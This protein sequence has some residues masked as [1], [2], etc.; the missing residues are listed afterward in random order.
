MRWACDRAYDPWNGQRTLASAGSSPG[1]AAAPGGSPSPKGRQIHTAGSFHPA[2]PPPPGQSPRRFDQPSTMLPPIG[3]QS[4]GE[5]GRGSGTWVS[6]AEEL[7]CSGAWGRGR[8]GIGEKRCQGSASRRHQ[9][10]AVSHR[11]GGTRLDTDKAAGSPLTEVGGGQP[12]FADVF[13]F[14]CPPTSYP[15]SDASRRQ[16]VRGGEFK[17]A[18]MQERQRLALHAIT[19]FRQ[20]RLS[21]MHVNR[22]EAIQGNQITD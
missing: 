11:P 20:G 6:R 14:R 1:T 5:S 12:R 13:S 10:S 21:S 7:G 2:S 17:T 15:A 8:D 22:E 4:Q 3:G 18:K 19:L 9:P 16:H